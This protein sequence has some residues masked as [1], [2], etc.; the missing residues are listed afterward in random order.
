MQTLKFIPPLFKVTGAVVYFLFFYSSSYGLDLMVDLPYSKGR[1]QHSSTKSKQRQDTPNSESIPSAPPSLKNKI[2]PFPQLECL[3]DNVAF[4][5]KIYSDVE[6][7]EA[8]VHDKNDLSR[9]YAII[10]LPS[11]EKQRNIFLK[12]QKKL[13]Q[14][15]LQ[16]LAK[17]IKG[18]KKLNLEEKRF[19][20]LFSNEEFSYKLLMDASLQI[21]IQTGLKSRFQ[22]G[23]RRSMSYMPEVFPIIEK[24]GL[25]LD[26]I[27]LPHVES[28]YNSKAGS[29]V[30]AKGLWQLM[31]STMR[32]LEGKNAIAK[33]TNPIDST[34]AAMKLLKI[35]YEKT[36]QWPLALTAYNHG[37]NGILRA[38]QNTNSAN[39][40][41]II[42]KYN[43]PSFQF[44][45]SN[46]YAQFLA[47]R[48][49][50]KK[51]Y[52]QKLQHSQKV[53]QNNLITTIGG[54][55]K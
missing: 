1:A 42:E 31:P 25:P 5:K 41:T 6:V 17:K 44:A 11:S 21:R 35:N 4:W 28:S 3:K 7:N 46:F 13:F 45:S 43:S 51:I 15:K 14:N 2:D 52:L 30:G 37:T 39:L 20:K 50:A 48:Q 55:L 36:G 29:K 9:I 22:A 19:A 23:I 8:I 38:M 34:R 16:T 47:A 53:A 24:S 49:V 12:K 18:H 26:L 10:T 33:R 32:N 40:C 54:I 27:Y